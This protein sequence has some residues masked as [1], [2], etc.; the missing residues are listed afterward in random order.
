MIARI[1]L[2]GKTSTTLLFA[3]VCCRWWPL[4]AAR[5]VYKREKRSTGVVFLTVMFAFLEQI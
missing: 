2:I 4:K 5:K 3:V 1:A